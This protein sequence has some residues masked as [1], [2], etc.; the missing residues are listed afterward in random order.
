MRFP[1]LV[2]MITLLPAAVFGADVT[3]VRY[4]C[5]RGAQVV[6]TYL[7]AGEQSFAVVGF[8]GRQ[9]G[10]VIGTSASGARYV[11]SDP[12]QPYVWWTK[13]DTAILLHGTGD[14]EAMIYGDC[15]AVK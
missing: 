3:T 7:N 15:A 11:S 9:L 4:G 1:L 2:F 10:F 13:G 12:A 14:A 5:D 6:A 8:E